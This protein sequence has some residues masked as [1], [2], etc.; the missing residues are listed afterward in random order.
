MAPFTKTNKSFTVFKKDGV[1]S[2]KESHF[3]PGYTPAHLKTPETA[4]DYAIRER[5]RLIEDLNSQI[6]ELSRLRSTIS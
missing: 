2:I 4:I 6:Q 1:F 3:V 5:K